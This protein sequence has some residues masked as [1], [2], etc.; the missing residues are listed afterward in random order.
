MEYYRKYKYVT[1]LGAHWKVWTTNCLS[2]SIPWPS[3]VTLCHHPCP[4]DGRTGIWLHNCKS[5]CPS[6]R[7]TYVYVA[8]CWLRLVQVPVC[9]ARTCTCRHNYSNLAQSRFC[10][11][12]FMLEGIRL[13]IVWLILDFLRTVTFSPGVLDTDVGHYAHLWFS[14]FLNVY[15]LYF[16]LALIMLFCYFTTIATPSI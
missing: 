11:F 5:P 9:R 2:S 13:T 3:A 16:S 10:I 1:S 6:T 12:R 7:C 15:N 14:L 4:T 8:I